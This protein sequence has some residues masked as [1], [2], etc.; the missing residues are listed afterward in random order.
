MSPL[1]EGINGDESKVEL[2]KKMEEGELAR[3][4]LLAGKG[5]NRKS[6]FTKDQM[7]TFITLRALSASP[8][9]MGGDLPTL[10]DFSFKLITN[11]DV[12][13][14]NQN[15][16]MGSLVYDTGGIEIWKAP[17]QNSKDGWIGIFNRMEE[18]NSISLKHENLGLDAAESYKFHD[19]W[20]NHEVSM[21]DFEI[22]PNGVV[23]FAYSN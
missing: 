23:F 18:I 12:L 16:V 4:E 6:K 2:V 22:N 8:L 10:D 19:V 15:G 3:F 7:Y 11:K 20:N 5:F 1:P 9:M 21:L 17:K 14:C 13:E